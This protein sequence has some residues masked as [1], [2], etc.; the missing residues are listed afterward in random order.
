MPTYHYEC[1]KCGEI[2]EQFRLSYKGTDELELDCVECQDKTKHNKTLKGI[3]GFGIVKK[4]KGWPDKDRKLDDHIAWT[5]RVMAEP[6]SDSEMKEGK[7]MMREREKEKGYTEGTLTGDRPTETVLVESKS[8]HSIDAKR[9]AAQLTHGVKTELTK[10]VTVSEKLRG[11]HYGEQQLTRDISAKARDTAERV[12]ADKKKSGD[13]VE[14]KR[15]KRQG[16]QKMKERAKRQVQER[17]RK[18]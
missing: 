4:G 13:I 10:D 12:I 6:V 3:K 7:D 14:V 15:A 8:G 1:E 11:S 5:Q 9:M 2:Q 18:V 16:K 17:L